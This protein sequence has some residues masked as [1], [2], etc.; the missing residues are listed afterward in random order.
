MTSMLEI[1]V[2]EGSGA[3]FMAEQRARLFFEEAGI[4]RAEVLRIHV[5]ARGQESDREGSMRSDLAP[6]VPALQSVSLFGDAT[7]VL[8]LEANQLLAGEAT[9]IASLLPSIDPDATRLVVISEGAPPAP[10]AKA[11]AA[12]GAAK[13]DIKAVREKDAAQWLAEEAKQRHLRMTVGARNALLE[14]FG[15][16][17]AAMAGAM[18]QLESG[19]GELD[20]DS[21]R[22]RFRNRPDEPMW[23]FAD[24][25]DAGD[26]GQALRRLSDF[27]VHGH[28]LQLLGYLEGDLRR[29]ALAKSAPNEAVY[30]DWAGMRPGDWRIRRDWSRGRGMST[31]GIRKATEALGRADRTLKTAPEDMHRVTMER[32]TVALAIWYSGRG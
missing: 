8:L 11:L 15:T 24:A 1:R 27:L 2:R 3:A 13:V 19:K 31:T 7:G 22:A 25:L 12:C 18:D 16:D 21:I 28:P 26:A 9:T 23:L 32:L 14:S 20:E 6:L 30:A 17:L 10:L 29:R 4:G 5:P